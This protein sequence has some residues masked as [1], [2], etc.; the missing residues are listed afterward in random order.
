MACKFS[1]KRHQHMCFPAKFAQ[2]SRNTYFKEHLWMTASKSIP[3]EDCY[4]TFSVSK[5]DDFELHCSW[6]YQIYVLW[7]VS[8]R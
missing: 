7:I 8:S 1:K 5:Y 2:L 4:K 6:N 3:G